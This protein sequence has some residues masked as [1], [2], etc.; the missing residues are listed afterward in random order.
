[1]SEDGVGNLLKFLGTEHQQILT[2]LVTCREEFDAFS[3][4]DA[5]YQAVLANREVSGQNLVLHQLFIFAHYHLYFAISTLMR[6]HLSE[7]FASARVAIDAALAAAIMIEDRSLQAAY[8]K[9]EKPFDK[10]V[11]HYKN[12]IRD[13]KSV[14]EMVPHLIKRHDF[15]S[16]YASHADMDVFIH[17]SSVIEGPGD[18]LAVGYFQFPDSPNMMR[19]Y[20]LQLL[21]DFIVVLDTFSAFFVDEIRFAPENWRQALRGLGNFVEDRL[22]ILEPTPTK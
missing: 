11:R 18:V 22:R 14:P 12:L 13:S 7:A 15:C 5:L 20:I 3:Q 4:L 17:R 1:M 2:T 6:C 9:R 19:M 10:L 16:R 8:I 21:H